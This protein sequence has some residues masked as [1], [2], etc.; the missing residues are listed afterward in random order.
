MSGTRCRDISDT[1]IIFDLGKEYVGFLSFQIHSPCVQ[2]ITI[3]YGEHLASGCVRRKIDTRDFS[4]S[5][6][7]K[8]GDNIF[9]NPFRR[10]GCR[11]LELTSE[12]PVT[13]AKMAIAPTM[14]TVTEKKRPS[15]NEKQNKIY[16][17]CI[18]TLRLCMHEHYEDCPWRE[19]ALYAMDSR[20]QMLCGYYAFGEFQFPRANLQLISKDARE[21]N[22]LSICY[23]MKRD[24]LIPSFSLHYI[25]ACAEYLQY[26]G[27]KAFLR[28]IYPKLTSI[29]GAFTDRIKNGLVPI[30][31]EEMYWNFYEWRDG[32][33]NWDTPK[34][35][36]D[37]I[38]NSLLSIALQKMAFIAEALTIDNTYIEQ[39]RTLNLRIRETF[40]DAREGIC[41]MHPEHTAY[42]QLGNA[43]AI[44]CGI[45]TDSEAKAL[46]QRILDDQRMVPVSLSMSG[47]LYDALI[48]VD[49]V[50]YAPVILEMIDRIYT[51]M[52]D[53]GSTTV[54]ETEVGESDFGNAGSLCHGWSALPVYYYHIL[55]EQ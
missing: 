37:S 17:M 28:E 8:K 32:L 33:S 1:D 11:Y 49:R 48:K 51:P 23:P 35:E 9:M 27:D 25:T 2:D 34:Q 20:N 4:I 29:I 16:E 24:R 26:S 36:Y 21:D 30:F 47:F 45:V 39:V 13:V 43:L 6:R 18:E 14:Y 5:Y 55:C 50:G 53:F 19:Q 3:S 38:L 46:C 10:F 22:L 52:V 41:Y 31:R 42:S 12:Y 40:W 15:L 44:L 54:W 7:A